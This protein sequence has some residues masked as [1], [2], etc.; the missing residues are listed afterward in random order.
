MCE[1]P[2]KAD[3]DGGGQNVLWTPTNA[4]ARLAIPGSGA[5]TPPR[6]ALLYG[7]GL[8]ISE[9]LGLKRRD[10]P[11]PG[12]GDVVIVNGKGNKTRM[13]PGAAERCSR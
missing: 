3:P 13:V 11:L 5:R 8:R 6:L 9:A 7:S 2:A 1:E 4:P 10:V 12:A